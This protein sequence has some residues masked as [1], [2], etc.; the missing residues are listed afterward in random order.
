MALSKTDVFV[1]L[2]GAAVGITAVAQ[3]LPLGLVAPL[4]ALFAIFYT[5]KIGPRFRPAR[6][7]PDAMAGFPWAR[8]VVVALILALGAVFAVVDVPWPLIAFVCGLLL[9]ALAVHLFGH[10]ELAS[11]RSATKGPGTGR[12]IY[13]GPTVS[14]AAYVAVSAAL[15]VVALIMLASDWRIGAVT[16]VVFAPC[17]YRA[18]VAYRRKSSQCRSAI[19]RAS[20]LGQVSIPV[21]RERLFGW[22]SSLLLIGLALALVDSRVPMPVRLIG[23][24]VA[25]I[26]GALLISH[27]AGFLPR[28]TLRFEP[29]GIVFGRFSHTITVPWDAMGEM[30]TGQVRSHSAVLIRLVPEGIVTVTP[31]HAQQAWVRERLDNLGLFAADLMIEPRLYGFDLLSLMSALTRYAGDPNS[32]GELVRREPVATDAVRAA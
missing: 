31:H 25:L 21:S 14:D 12:S 10:V 29:E 15:C 2:T 32:R 26:S 27:L 3:G 28:R 7:G 8:L 30:V 4:G 17:L 1:T 6:R 18:V 9:T 5:Y 16:L 23:A 11:L 24:V 13:R 22:S 19:L 20:I